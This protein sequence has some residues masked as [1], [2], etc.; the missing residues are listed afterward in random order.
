MSRINQVSVRFSDKELK[1]LENAAARSRRKLADF[2]R[3]VVLDEVEKTK[4]DAA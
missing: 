1:S 2:L 4:S 3:A